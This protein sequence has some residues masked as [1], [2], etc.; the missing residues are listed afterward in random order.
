MKEK[1]KM[2]LPFCI[3]QMLMAYF[4]MFE[5][6][7]C[8]VQMSLSLISLIIYIVTLVRKIK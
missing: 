2:E 1:R 6:T 7:E 4:E 3:S 8:K 5:K